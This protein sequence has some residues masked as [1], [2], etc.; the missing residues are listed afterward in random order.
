[1]SVPKDKR[2]E[3]ELAI[4]VEARRICT[5]VLQITGNEKN[6]P[7]EQEWFNFRLRLTALSIDINCWKANN[8]LVGNSEKLYE[9]R[10]GLEAEAGD[11][12]TTMLELIN[13]GR[14]LYHM[15]TKRYRYLSEQYV[16]LRKKIRNWYKSDRDRLKP[17][18]DGA[19]S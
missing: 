14:S 8:I 7:R 18:N 4:N 6:F 5:H 12:C 10:L 11:A 15:P 3:G 19:V 16:N 2:K 13:I 17:D 1:M 9:K